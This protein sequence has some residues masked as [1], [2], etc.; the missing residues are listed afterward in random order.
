MGILHGPITDSGVEIDIA[1]DMPAVLADKR[2]VSEVMQ[3]LIENAIK[4]C[5]DVGAPKISV[6]AVIRDNRVQCRVGDNGIGIDPRYHDKVFGL[7]DRLDPSIDGSGVGLALVKRIV[8]LHDGKVWIESEGAGQGT[9]VVF[10]L[11][12][13]GA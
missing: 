6:D 7:V 9:Q 11:P 1:P 2:Q 10:T 12:A 4:F 13:A 3:N 5:G 8:E